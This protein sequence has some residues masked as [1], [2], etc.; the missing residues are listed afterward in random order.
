MTHRKGHIAATAL[1]ASLLAGCTMT[2]QSIV[3]DIKTQPW[4]ES[5]TIVVPNEDTLALRDASFFLRCNEEFKEDSLTVRLRV[6][7]PH[8]DF[9]E[10]RLQVIVPTKKVPAPLSQEAVIPYRNR[11]RLKEKCRYRFTL[12]PCRKVNGIESAGIYFTKSK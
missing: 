4:K 11:L 1:A 5:V 10:E 3:V 8:S 9:C 2:G 12:T 7:T 6:S